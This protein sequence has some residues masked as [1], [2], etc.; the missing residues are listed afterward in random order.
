MN[1]YEEFALIGILLLTQ[2]AFQNGIVLAHSCA[3]NQVFGLNC[4]LRLERVLDVLNDL[5]LALS[6]GGGQS[7]RL[8]NDDCWVGGTGDHVFC[9]RKS[10]GVSGGK[11]GLEDSIDLFLLR[12]LVDDPLC[13][14]SA[15]SVEECRV[16]LD[17]LLEIRRVRV[18][19]GPHEASV[20]AELDVV[21]VEDRVLHLVLLALEGFDEV[22]W[23][24]LNN[25]KIDVLELLNR[26]NKI[27]NLLP[28][29]HSVQV[30]RFI[31]EWHDDV[32]LAWTHIC[33]VLAD[34]DKLVSFE[35]LIVS[36]KLWI[37]DIR[38]IIAQEVYLKMLWPSRAFLKNMRQNLFL[39]TRV[40]SKWLPNKRL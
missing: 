34:V 30:S 15:L 27:I 8:I 18:E 21:P 5:R 9:L 37:E 32:L 19:A 12:R 3:G 38:I 11:L 7:V 16:V 2:W 40:T 4:G 36:L 23:R 13:E 22:T 20:L 1:G 17:L 35:F 6:K 29:Y 14:E 28:V 33:N 10:K 25:C 39:L 24:R 31:T 26:C